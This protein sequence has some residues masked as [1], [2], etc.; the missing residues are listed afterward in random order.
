M[1]EAELTDFPDPR[2]D[3]ISCIVVGV[4]CD[5][6]PKLA[7]HHEWDVTEKHFCSEHAELYLLWYLDDYARVTVGLE[8]LTTQREGEEQ[9]LLKSE[10][11]TRAQLRAEIE[12]AKAAL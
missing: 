3:Y 4:Y 6:C 9:E 2:P 11:A 7:E 8:P 1:A 5:L 12:N 10:N